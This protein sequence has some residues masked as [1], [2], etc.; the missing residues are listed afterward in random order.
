MKIFV[1]AAI[2]FGF[3]WE[4]AMVWLDARWQRTHALPDCVR[5]V[6]DEAEYKRW[7]QYDSEKTR[8]MLAA[9]GVQAAVQGG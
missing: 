9:N 6:Y 8:L 7:R 4:A 1:I 5:D 3:C 2:L